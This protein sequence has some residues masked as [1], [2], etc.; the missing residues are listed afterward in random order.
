MA[1]GMNTKQIVLSIV[2]LDFLAFTVWVVAEHGFV[3]TF[4]AVL[5][6][7]PGVQVATDLVIALCMVMAWM[8]VDARKLGLSVAPFVVAT[9]VAGSLGPL[10][11]LIRREWALA[12]RR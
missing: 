1:P 2:T 4:A 8:V 3:G 9:L 7:W 5:S 11:Y 6:T 10:A 12:A